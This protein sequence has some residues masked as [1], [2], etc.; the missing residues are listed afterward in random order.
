MLTLLRQQAELLQSA[1]GAS[2]DL[3]APGFWVQ[4]RFDPVNHLDNAAPDEPT[5]RHL[6]AND[7][8]DNSFGDDI[9]YEC[10]YA[11]IVQFFRWEEDS[12]CT[13]YQQLPVYRFVL[14]LLLEVSLLGRIGYW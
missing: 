2:F 13:L 10:P 4:V 9:G 12:Q 1:T 3:C 14:Q 11:P 5:L 6:A 8:S 7:V